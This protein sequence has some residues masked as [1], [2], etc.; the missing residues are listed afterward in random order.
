MPE[1]AFLAKKLIGSLLLPP[2][3][4]LWIGALGLL[5]LLRRRHS[6]LALVSAGLL[7]GLVL[8]LPATVGPMV[9]ALET[10]PVPDAAALAR[11]QALVILGGGRRSHAPEFGGPDTVNRLTLERVRY[12]ARLARA[13]GLPVLV[14]GG[15]P[16]GQSAE[17][18][19]MARS[20]EEDFG[21][22][23]RWVER[24][25][26]DTSQN[27]QLSAPL[28]RSA[29]VT[30]VVLVTHALHMRRA[31]AEFE[32]AGLT[33]IAAPTGHFSGRG[34]SED[35]LAA[36]PSATT[37]F[38]GWYALHEWLGIAAQGLRGD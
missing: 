14:T 19:L 2:L 5:M 18:D 12:G 32:R 15:A 31:R 38:A 17:A 16:T 20:L 10:D 3:L 28:L 21:L 33:V 9:R 23:A 30:R 8:S 13:T 35:V 26:L 24:T 4:P 34:G 22:K 27:A 11:G 1:I 37:A 6:G 36:L 25:S 29:G 7:C